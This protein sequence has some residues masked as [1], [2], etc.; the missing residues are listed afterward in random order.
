MF[1][2]KKNTTGPQGLE[3]T[4]PAN[5]GKG[6]K[7]ATLNRYVANRLTDS[8][9]YMNLAVEKHNAQFRER[10]AYA[11]LAIS[12]GFNG[13]SQLQNKYIPYVVQMDQIGHVVAVGVANEARPIDD[14]RIIRGQM[15][16]WVSDV[17]T[18]MGDLTF[19]KRTMQRVY[20]HVSEGS[21]AKR[22]L[23]TFYAE[24]EVF[25]RAQKESVEAEVTLALPTGD[26]FEIEWTETI[27]SL[28]G[29]I[30]G[31]ER[32]RGRFTFKI[33]PQDTEIGIKKNASGFFITDFAWTK[34]I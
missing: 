7:Q 21:K 6:K 26:T 5:V 28:Q 14:K 22:M 27:R 11:L 2:R 23:D 10:C 16:D 34:Q 32:W 3:I 4:A 19:Q 20:A 25:K 30:I 29:D 31:R 15:M 33:Q 1:G 18:V 12:I 13:Y 9:R 17:R 24:R 8:D